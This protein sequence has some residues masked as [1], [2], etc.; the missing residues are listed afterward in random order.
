MLGFDLRI[1]ARR[2]AHFKV[3]ALIYVL[4]NIGLIVLN[5]LTAPTVPWVIAPLVGWGIGLGCHAIFVYS[6]GLRGLE[7]R[8]YQKLKRKQDR[9][10]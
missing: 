9:A 2:R 1:M 5:A 7:E 10:S 6:N 8:E 3:H 4:V